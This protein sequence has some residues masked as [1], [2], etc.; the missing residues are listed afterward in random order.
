MNK[1]R[2]KRRQKAVPNKQNKQTTIRNI[3]RKNKHRNKQRQ[4][5]VIHKQKI[6]QRQ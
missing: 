5:A 2:N 3:E 4:R 6:K 1:Q